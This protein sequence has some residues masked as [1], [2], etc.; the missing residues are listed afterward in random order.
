MNTMKTTNKLITRLFAGLMMLGLIQSSI[1]A[2]AVA[3]VKPDKAAKAAAKAEKKAAKKA[4]KRAK[5]RSADRILAEK[6]AEKMAFVAAEGQDFA[7]ARDAL[8]KSR[9]VTRQLLEDS[10]IELDEAKALD[11]R[12][13]AVIGARFREDLYRA[14]V[15]TTDEIVRQH[16]ARDERQR[17]QALELE[18]TKSAIK[19]QAAQLLASAE[20]LAALA[21]PPLR[22][23]RSEFFNQLALGL[24]GE[25]VGDSDKLSGGKILASKLADKVKGELEADAGLPK[26]GPKVE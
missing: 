22:G 2:A 20:S 11:L 4:A 7:N 18:E 14:V 21:E 13:W 6:L 1:P 15:E 3:I 23:D 9:L 19:F 26:L 17:A 25:S 16:H 8:A 10:L 5:E 24:A 12:A